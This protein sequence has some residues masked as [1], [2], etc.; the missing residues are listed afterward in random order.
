MGKYV[1]ETVQVVR[2]KYYVEVEDPTWAHDGVVMNELEPFSY[3]HH[4]EDIITTTP[5]IDFPRAER[6]DSVNGATMH[7]NKETDTWDQQVR[8]D[9]A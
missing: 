9:L 3:T 6:D 1:V 4:S 2:Y 8:W 7:F 5:V